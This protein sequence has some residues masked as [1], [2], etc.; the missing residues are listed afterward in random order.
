MIYNYSTDNPEIIISLIELIGKC[1]EKLRLESELHSDE[2]S[3]KLKESEI[4][5]L[6]NEIETLHQML[7]QLDSQKSEA[8]KRLDDLGN[9]VFISDLYS[10]FQNLTFFG[11]LCFI[12]HEFCFYL[13]V[14]RT[15]KTVRK[16]FA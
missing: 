7:K 5:S 8:R 11:F 14:L 15:E 9:Q 13:I 10:S 2:A 1:R 3:I 16:E 6:Q 4:K 12:S